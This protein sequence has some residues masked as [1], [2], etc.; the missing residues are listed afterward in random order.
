MNLLRI[1]AIIV[2]HMSVYRANMARLNELLL[3]PL[4]ELLLWGFFGTYVGRLTS[5]TS[6]IAILLG[7]LLLYTVFARVQQS[8]AVSFLM[9]LWSRNLM[10]IFVSPISVWEY[11][12]ALMIFGLMK[13]T[14]IA[15]LMWTITLALYKVNLLMIGPALVPLS[16][17]LI[18]FAWA[19]G[20]II[21]SIVLRFGQG[22]ESIAWMFAFFLQPFGAIFFPLSVYPQWLQQ[23][24]WWIP[25]P[26]V[27]ES[28]RSVF[29]GNGLPPE[30]LKWAFGLD[31]IYL[32]AAFMIF[33]YMFERARDRGF[34]M[35]LQE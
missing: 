32:V 26:H 25:L 27:F 5:A 10:N 28:M 4:F 16:L 6:V 7:A 12:V 17:A 22:A 24:L 14:F 31:A 2:R 20:T 33:G 18:L 9:E 11:I 23:I 15:V 19:V 3:W 29:A 34:L 13:V 35:K 30:H 1:W 21:T 8:I